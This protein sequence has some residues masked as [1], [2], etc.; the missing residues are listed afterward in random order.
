MT[1]SLPLSQW[2]DWWKHNGGRELRDLLLIWWDPIG[3][4][5]VPE[6]TSEYD[7]YSGTVGRL[8]REG[9]RVAEITNF[10]REVEDERITMSGDAP[11]AAHKIIEW[12]DRVMS[13][14]DRNH[15]LD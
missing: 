14:L 12:Y 4:Y 15:T 10:L 6:A 2:H 3:V 9:A 7:S 8:L 1:E 11:N 13:Q 5:G